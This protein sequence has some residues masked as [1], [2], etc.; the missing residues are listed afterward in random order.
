MYNKNISGHK[1]FLYRYLLAME[2]IFR[3]RRCQMQIAGFFKRIFKK[4]HWGLNHLWVISDPEKQIRITSRQPMLF[5]FWAI[6]LIWSLIQ[7]NMFSVAGLSALS[8]L[9]LA[10]YLWNRDM[11][12]KVSASRKL[13]YAA[14]Q[15]GDEIAEEISLVNNS[16]LP[17]LWAEFKDESNLPGYRLQGVRAANSFGKQSWRARTLCKKRGLFRLGP[18]ELQLGDPFSIFST[19][20]TW[21]DYQEIL[22]YPQLVSLPPRLLKHQGAFGDRSPLRQPLAEKNILAFSTRPYLP[23]DPLRHIHWKTT[24]RQAETFVKIFDPET[25][26]RVWLLPDLD[27][28]VHSGEEE[29]STLETIISLCASLCDLLLREQLCVGFFCGGEKAVVLQP[30]SGQAFIWRLL[31][32]ISPLQAGSEFHL[33]K[34][35]NQSKGIIQKNDLVILLT[36]SLDPQLAERLAGRFIPSRVFTLLTDPAEFGGQEGITLQRELLLKSGISAN[37]LHKNEL[38]PLPGIY[39]K[40]QAWEFKTL[41]T[42]RVIVTHSPRP[43]QNSRP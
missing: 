15:V 25:A 11:A 39:G 16:F 10:S 14:F 2:L 27:K 8:T 9:L 5:I 18:W 29:N 17:V 35:L 21:S 6:L 37:I 40:K 34:I 32:A 7:V 26:S 20:I 13:Q 3:K 33:E 24:A 12:L 4:T 30:Q 38:I 42:G 43:F 22:V 1:D 19:K 31:R 23:G 28:N 36:P 41:G